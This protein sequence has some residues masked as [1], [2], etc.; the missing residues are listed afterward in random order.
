M[1]LLCLLETGNKMS[2]LTALEALNGVLE[3]IG[4]E[5]VTVLTGLTGIQ[6]IAW[7]KLN[8]SVNDVCSDQDGRWKFLESLG[9]ITMTT[10]NNE[11]LVSALTSGSDINDED[12]ESFKQTDSGKNI[13]YLTPQ[14]FD[15]MYPKGI[16]TD[17][18]G[19]PDYFTKYADTFV[20]DKQA[21]AT[22]NGKTIDFRYWK[23]PTYY[24]T[25]TATGTSEIPEGFDKNV[26]VAIATMKVL[27]YLGNDEVLSY[28]TLVYGDGRDLE[29]SIDK[30]KRLY[31]SPT[32]KPRMTYRF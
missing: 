21:T 7:N 25:S 31:T 17:R 4:E 3:N 26:I 16:S 19:Y 23:T 11:Y 10:G 9:E 24:S 18:T 22:Q 29:G 1:R 8:E 14:E 28:K 13:T 27:S 30:L 12:R 32:L 20:V 2:K 15:Q 5:Q 6:L